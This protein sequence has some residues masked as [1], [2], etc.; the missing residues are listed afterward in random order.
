MLIWN[1]SSWIVFILA[2]AAS[3]VSWEQTWATDL[4]EEINEWSDIQKY[5]PHGLVIC[6]DTEKAK[7]H[8]CNMNYQS[9]GTFMEQ[10]YLKVK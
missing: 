9:Y 3:Y 7:V 6:Y 2:R 5:T 1:H 4:L 10:S 8:Y